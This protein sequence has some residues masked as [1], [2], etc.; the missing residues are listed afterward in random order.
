VQKTYV[1]CTAQ[2][3][4]CQRAHREHFLRCS[5]AAPAVAPRSGSL[6]KGYQVVAMDASIAMVKAATT[7]TGRPVLHMRLEEIEWVEEATIT[8]R[9]TAG[10]ADQ[11][12]KCGI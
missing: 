10:A 6:A 1:F 4:G 3:A 2:E 7:L 5:S 11:R 9:A 12:R 8:A